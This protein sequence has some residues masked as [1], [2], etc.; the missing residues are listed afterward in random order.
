MPD[1]DKVEGFII[2]LES[3]IP[4]GLDKDVQKHFG[5]LMNLL[6]YIKKD[7][8]AYLLAHAKVA[9]KC[10]LLPTPNT[11]LAAETINSISFTVKGAHNPFIAIIRGGTPPTRVILGL[12]MLLYIAIPIMMVIWP[13]FKE[14]QAI[15]GVNTN[16]LIMVSLAGALGSIVSIMVRIHEFSNK[17]DVDPSVLF[18]TGFFKPVVGAAFAM[19]VLSVIKAGLIPVKIEPDAETY[20]YLALGFVSGF[21]ERFAKDVAEKTES[22]VGGTDAN[23]ANAADATNRAAD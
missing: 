13:S 10:L 15:L 21:S 12:G 14:N 23:K 19:F 20:F 22:L 7:K 6:K 17:K 3:Q 1:I 5:R 18:F 4:E 8:Y 2:E 11:K 9:A 16:L